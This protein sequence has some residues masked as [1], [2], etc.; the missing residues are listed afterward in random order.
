MTFF[1]KDKKIHIDAFISNPAVPKLFPVEKSNKFVPDWWKQIPSIVPAVGKNPEVPI[2]R[3]TIKKCPGFFNLYNLG[4]MIPLWSDIAIKTEESGKCSY[5]YSVSMRAPDI[6]PGE[7]HSPMQ[8]NYNFKDFIHFKF[9]SPWLFREKT[10][11][12]FLFSEPSWNMENHLNKLHVLPGIADFKTQ[13]ASNINVFLPK[14]DNYFVLEAGTPLVQLIPI[15]EKSIELEIHEVGEEEYRR[16]ADR[17]S[18]HFSFKGTTTK[19][20]NILNGESY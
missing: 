5:D 10:G 7:F 19:K 4:F 9:V 17:N 14:T 6:A 1:F 3:P 8:L 18:Y 20:Y 16:I 15:S 11:V 2:Q 12:K 13:N